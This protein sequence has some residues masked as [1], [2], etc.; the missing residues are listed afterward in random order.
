MVLKAFNP[1][2]QRACRYLNNSEDG[3]KLIYIYAYHIKTFYASVCKLISALQQPII[4]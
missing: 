3:T 1:S 4:N 2:K